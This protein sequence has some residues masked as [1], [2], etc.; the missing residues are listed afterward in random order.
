[1]HLG[2]VP[3]LANLFV[4]G[5]DETGSDAGKETVELHGRP[6]ALIKV[7]RGTAV[8]EFD[9]PEF[10]T[11]ALDDRLRSVSGNTQDG[12]PLGVRERWASSRRNANG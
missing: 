10:P 7:N 4:V 1:L 9:G 5:Q 3:D 8:A 6:P 2:C 12:H 11:L